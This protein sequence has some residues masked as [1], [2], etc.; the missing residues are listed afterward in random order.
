MPLMQRDADVIVLGAGLAGLSAAKALGAA[1]KSVI[2]IDARNRA[3]GRVHTVHDAATD[4]P[5]ELG[6]EW[7][8]DGELRRLLNSVNANVRTTHGVHLVRTTGGLVSR[9]NFD[10]T[11]EIMERIAALLMDGSDYT[12]NEAL[13]RCCPEPEFAESRASLVSYVQG[14]HAADPERVSARW[15][16]EVEENEPADASEG[17][18]L[19][20]LDQAVQALAQQATDKVS[21][22]FDTVVRHVHWSE[23]GVEVD[24]DS[25]GQTVRLAA[26]QLICALP[27]AILQ[28][29]QDD[30]GAVQF[31]PALTM[32]RDALKQLAMGPVVKVLLV[33][34]EPFWNRID[35]LKHASFI[36][37]PGLPFPTW[38]TTFPVD[39]PVLTG[40][41]AGPL[42]AG[43]GGRHGDALLP[44]AIDSAAAV[45][46]VT[47]ERV[48]QQLRSWH[49]HDWSADPFARGGYSYVLS[50]GT[51][52][53]R[54]LAQSVDN[55]LFFAGEATCG[56][57][58][59]ATM[60]GALQSG[61]RAATE[62]LACG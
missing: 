2:V 28:S 12:L 35:D 56:Q 20:G 53:H 38:W 51:G 41:V 3:G 40:W 17:H 11:N 18:A 43:L 55:T 9:E 60:E 6:P 23:A 59:N 44:L 57:G 39:A 50:G 19:A 54:E 4:Y 21:F 61:L 47:G 58:H 13:N 34:D 24:A 48:A 62:L 37:Q 31:T 22:R 26:S 49:T 27:L 42:V 7:V 29:H 16:L 52:A 30:A 33:F 15:L 46:G 5:I 25:N 14:F 10:E 32:K 36:Q 8:G 1:G 45:L